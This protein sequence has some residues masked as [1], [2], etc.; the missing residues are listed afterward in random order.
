MPHG[1]SAPAGSAARAGTSTPAGSAARTGTSARSLARCRPGHASSNQI[2]AAEIGSL[3]AA[4]VQTSRAGA[5]KLC[6]VTRAGHSIESVIIPDGD[7]TT[8]CISS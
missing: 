2:S 6:L 1:A 5:H 7:K 8:Q 4:E 3:E